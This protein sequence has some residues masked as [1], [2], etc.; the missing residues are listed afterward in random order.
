MAYQNTHEV[1]ASASRGDQVVVCKFL[2][3]G[4]EINSKN[5]NSHSLL[6]L[7]AYN[8]HYDLSKFLIDSGADINSVDAAGNSILMG[9]VFKGRGHIFDL[10]VEA[11]VDLNYRNPKKQ[12]ALDFAVLFGRRDLIFKI[13]QALKLNR[14]AGRVEQVKT[15]IN[16][17][18]S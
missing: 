13:N 8:G 7:A 10:L 12:T 1:F 3:E 15:W 6:M 2:S 16:Y 5:E 14:S 4:F 11:G 9:V 18:K 17:V